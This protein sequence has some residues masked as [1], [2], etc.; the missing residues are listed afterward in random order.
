MVAMTTSMLL[1]IASWN[2]EWDA[3]TP[4]PKTTDEANEEKNPGETSSSFVNIGHASFATV[5]TCDL[6]RVIWPHMWI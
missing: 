4:K 6:D 1:I 5:M 2:T 3:A